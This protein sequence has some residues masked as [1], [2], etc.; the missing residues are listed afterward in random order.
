MYLVFP[1]PLPSTGSVSPR[2]IHP[3]NG[4]STNFA[5]TVHALSYRSIEIMMINRGDA[6]HGITYE[7]E[8]EH[9]TRRAAEH[10]KFCRCVQ[11]PNPS[12]QNGNCGLGNG[13]GG[14]LLLLWVR[15]PVKIKQFIIRQFVFF[16]SKRIKN[17]GKEGTPMR[18][19]R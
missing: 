19:I 17:R 7:R 10:Q 4:P 5:I 16:C 1:Y 11:N 18:E 2:R 15:V 3:L 8:R 12:P 9:Y 14:S 6:S 13:E